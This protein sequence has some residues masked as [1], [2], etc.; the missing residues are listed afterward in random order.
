MNKNANVYL[1]LQRIISCPS[2][3]SFIK[4]IKKNNIPNF[5][6]TITDIKDMEG[7]FVTDVGS[8]KIKTDRYKT[9]SVE[10]HYTNVPLE[11]MDR[12]K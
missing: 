1:K 5:P 2:A 6:F 7:L 4:Y 11:I 12:Y 9:N 8:I 3:R 10:S